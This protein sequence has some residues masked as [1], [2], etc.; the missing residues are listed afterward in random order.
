VANEAAA[1]GSWYALDSVLKQSQ[2]EFD[3]YWSMP[4][5]ACPQCGEPLTNAPTTDAGSGVQLYC[6]YDGW[7]YPR[8]QHAPTR[9]GQAPP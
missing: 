3:A 1:A 5:M 2:Q 9:L 7:Q 4:P 6:K 8:D